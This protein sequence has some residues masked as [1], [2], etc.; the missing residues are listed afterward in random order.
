[1]R[2]S[3]LFFSI[4]FFFLSAHC[5]QNQ[6]ANEDPI[7]LSQKILSA[8]NKRTASLNYEMSAQTQ[9]F[10]R[11]LKKMEEKLKQHLYK[12]DSNATRNLFLLNTNQQYSLIQNKINTDST[13]DDSKFAGNYYARTDTLTNSLKFLQQY[14]QLLQTNAAGMNEIKGSL[15][16]LQQ[17]E[18]KFQDAEQL[19]QFV[20]ERKEQIKQYLL[21]FT[22]LPGSVSSLYDEYNKELFYY[23]Q[24]V[25][26]YQEMLNDPDKIMKKMMTLLERLPAFQEFIKSNSVIAS[27]FPSAGNYGTSQAI[28]GLQTRDQISQMIS[29]QMGG[30]NAQS[31]L[32]DNVASAQSQLDDLKN[33]IQNYG[34]GGADIDMPDFKPNTQKTKSFLKRLEY[35]TNIQTLSSSYFFPATTDLG[36]SVGYKLNDKGSAIGFGGSVKVGWGRDISHLAISGQGASLRSYGDFKLKG[37]FYASG[38]L[39]YNYQQQFYSGDILK[40]LNSWQQSGLVG[41]SKIISIKTK[42]LKKTK[43]QLLWDF[44]SYE[45]VPKTQ[46]VK[47]RVGYSF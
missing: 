15:A 2:T 35:G 14:P 25:R 28:A 37:S 31:A 34:Q 19:K 8:L 41:I 1:M 4:L 9:Q 33:R 16:K 12:L 17:L 7:N 32:S 10:I 36:L 21:Q 30:P 22:H 39:E 24:Q 43:L 18:A 46:P 26:D 11:R 23:N 29:A 27:L 45:Q 40:S 47:F 42:M 3:F 38:G 5:Q 44:L 13:F 20:R 6:A